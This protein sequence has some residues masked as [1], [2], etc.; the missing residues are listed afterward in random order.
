M[1]EKRDRVDD[2]TL[3][4]YGGDAQMYGQA[5]ADLILGGDGNDVL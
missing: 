5:G 2:D 3:Y 4:G 1:T